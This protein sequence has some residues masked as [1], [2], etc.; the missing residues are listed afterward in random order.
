MTLGELREYAIAEGIDLGALTR[1]EDIYRFLVEKVSERAAE[2]G[3]R[4]AQ[5][6][7]E[8]RA[9]RT[10]A[11]RI[12]DVIRELPAIGKDSEAPSNMGGYKFRGIEAITAALKPLLGRH[13]VMMVPKVLERIPSERTVGT[14]KTMWVVDLLI[15][16][17]FTGA[18]GDELVATMWG[19]GTDMGDK[20]TQK[21]VTSAFKSMLAV[22]FCIADAG[23]DAE[24]HDVPETSR[25]RTLDGESLE[26][27][28]AWLTSV[29][30]TERDRVTAM[31]EEAWGPLELILQGDRDAVIDFIDEQLGEIN[32]PKDK[33]AE[34]CEECGAA[35]DVGVAHA[36][37]C[38]MRP[39]AEA[40][41]S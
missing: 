27:V 23:T 17:T 2:A 13:G 31:V 18:L 9:N 14:N 39:F 40:G 8:K 15:E 33:T 22:V 5:A 41:K 25:S 6:L 16:F 29:P 34:P 19:Q 24:E 36:E 35:T 28:R 12:H 4:D 20:A 32:A 21:A 3:Q 38:S 37:S 26:N 10:V 30:E 7:E 11:E 1:K